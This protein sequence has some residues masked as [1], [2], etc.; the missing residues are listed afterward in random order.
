MWLGVLGPLE[1]RDGKT[2]RNVPAAKQ[3]VLLGALL[4]HPGHVMSSYA[5]AEI[6]WD[7]A[8]PAGVRA[9]VRSYISRLRQRLGHPVGDRI[10]T[11]DPGYLLDVGDD[12]CDL[13]Q[14]TSLCAAGGR[15]VRAGAWQEA[16]RVL[17]DALRLW[18]ATPLVDIPS[19][20][21]HRDEVPRLEE[22]R[23]QA[24]EWR[25]EADLHIG[26]PDHVVPELQ[27][28]TAVQ[29]LRERLHGHLMLALYRCGRPAE[30][31]AAYRRAR[32]AL[33]DALGVE[34]AAELRRL[35]QRILMGDPDL[36][37]SGAARPVATAAGSP[38][39][40]AWTAARPARPRPAQLPSDLPDFTGRKDQ[41]ELLTGWLRR[42]AAR[43]SAGCVVICSIA[44]MGGVGKTTL[45]VHVA[46]V[47]R[48][49]F[50]DGQLYVDLRGTQPLR[51]S[52]DDVIGRFL[53][54]L[55]VPAQ[56]VPVDE[57]ERI[58]L[59]RSVLDGRRVLVVLDDAADVDQVRPL[60]PGSPG[61]AVVVTSRESMP[62]LPT[63]CAIELGAM[64]PAEALPLFCSTIG[65][66]RAA[67]EPEATAA[68]LA[69]CAGLPLAV[70]IA[71]QRLVRRPSWRVQTLADRLADERRR[72]DELR[73]GDLAVRASFLVSYSALRAW[74]GAGAT[75]AR[76]FRL[77]SL[78][79]GPTCGL[80]AATALAGLTP[81]VV[82]P[83]LESLVDAQML[84]APAPTRYRLHDL[85]AAYA[86]EQVW[87]EDSPGEQA[88][89]VHRLLSW[90]LHSA[91]AATRLLNPHRLHVNLDPAPVA[92]AAPDFGS[93]DQAREWLDEERENLVAAVHQAATWGLHEI[94][95][96]LSLT[97]WD[98]FVLR[99]H[100]SDWVTT[101]QAGLRST[102]TLG[103]R[104]AESRVLDDLA[105]AEAIASA[106]ASSTIVPNQ[107][108]GNRTEEANAAGA[109]QTQHVRHAR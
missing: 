91:A 18:R 19:Q 72:L 79:K 88:A 34:P 92:G 102:R 57:Q 30:A 42:G 5:L 16:S 12:E 73:I 29:P 44:G 9:T 17:G 107:R 70:R 83:A 77:L 7:G 59:Y 60:V 20:V 38:A 78:A 52:P 99:G 100:H 69:A 62:G 74:G 49:G 95:W 105:V 46:H 13:L 31:L 39:A 23:L 48:E 68:V 108:V 103:D 15:A 101:L 24:L 94:T 21:L 36:Q 43:T 64:R 82:E 35:H 55:G 33:I 63:S 45:A 28:L 2:V 25:I 32:A 58:L 89:A 90:Y 109:T 10:V 22:L 84:E 37:A 56:A 26:R 47:V 6:A 40:D 93:H 86:S 106:S 1:V 98:L 53:R 65:T 14:F 11:R 41:V 76:L 80:G 104:F 96:Q 50:G 97:M 61:C 75:A 54:D 81:E 4:V 66:Q 85:L 3:R 27:S 71:A 67:A 51:S 87:V 8:P